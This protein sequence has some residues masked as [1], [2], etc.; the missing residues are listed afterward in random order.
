MEL[1]LGVICVATLLLVALYFPLCQG[2]ATF[3]RGYYKNI[4]VELNQN[5]QLDGS[6]PEFL[7]KVEVIKNN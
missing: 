7:D 1:K 3:E 6:W 2:K 4:V 5:V